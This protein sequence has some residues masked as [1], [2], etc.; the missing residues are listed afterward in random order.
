MVA[1]A[2]GGSG[3]SAEKQTALTVALCAFWGMA[4]LGELVRSAK[5]PNQVLVKHLKWDPAGNFVTISIRDAE[6]IL[7]AHTLFEVK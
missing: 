4:R 6:A 2:R 3:T 7:S 1:C 5:N